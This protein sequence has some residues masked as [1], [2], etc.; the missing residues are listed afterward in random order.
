MPLGKKASSYRGAYR[1]PL[2]ILSV[3]VSVSVFVTLV[4]FIYCESCTKPIST[5]PGSTEVG[6]YGLTW[7]V[8]FRAPSQG[9]RGRRADV[10]SVVCFV[11]GGFFRAFHELGFSNSFVDPEQPA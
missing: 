5:S 11:W 3:C 2:F 7:D 4:V 9:D 8:G 6:E 10:D 1:V